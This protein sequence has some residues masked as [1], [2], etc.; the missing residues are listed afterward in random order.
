MDEVDVGL[1]VIIGIIVIVFGS[2]AAIYLAD[3]LAEGEYPKVQRKLSSV[4]KKKMPSYL[5][6]HEMNPTL[7]Y[8]LDLPEGSY[9]VR[10]PDGWQLA[11]FHTD[12]PTNIFTYTN[13]RGE[14]VPSYPYKDSQLRYELRGHTY[15]IKPIQPGEGDAKDARLKRL[16]D[17]IDQ[18]NIRLA[19]MERGEAEEFL[20]KHEKDRRRLEREK[21]VKHS[22]SMLG[23]GRDSNTPDD[24]ED[25]KE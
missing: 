20:P 10:K 12:D 2:A 5:R 1:V 21:G 15:H 13:D 7:T 3:K 19:S 9:E 17:L 14:E 6:F 16:Q 25:K 4:A 24:D 23:E 18:Q 22:G 11:K 8:V